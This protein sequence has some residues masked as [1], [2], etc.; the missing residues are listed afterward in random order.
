MRCYLLSESQK[1]N[2]LTAAV[3]LLAWWGNSLTK[4]YFACAGYGTAGLMIPL[5]NETQGTAFLLPMGL[6]FFGNNT[7]TINFL[8]S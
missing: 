5:L 2:R 4:C 7:L 8:Y 6:L 3:C 1:I